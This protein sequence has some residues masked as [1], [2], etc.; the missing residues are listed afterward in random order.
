MEI[1]NKETKIPF[2]DKKVSNPDALTISEWIN[3]AKKYYVTLGDIMEI[4][5]GEKIKFLIL[6]RNV[7]D[8]V[9]NT[10]K[11]NKAYEPAKFFRKSYGILKYGGNLQGTMKFCDISVQRP[12]EF[13]IEYKKDQ[14]YPL[15]NEYL[16][17]HDP[18]N[19]F[20]LLGKQKHYTEFPKSTHVGF[21][22]PMIFW[23]DM[24]NLPNIYW[25]Q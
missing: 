15:K 21:R 6:D 19:I 4:K 5:K 2:G 14:W 1:N 16:P 20:K 25:H 17:A 11:P 8:V 13:H 12:F 9:Q 3:N 10:N 22:G 23:Q 24:A 18:Q 7:L